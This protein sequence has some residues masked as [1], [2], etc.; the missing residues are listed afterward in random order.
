MLG[1]WGAIGEPPPASPPARRGH[2]A[3]QGVHGEGSCLHGDGWQCRIGTGRPGS[4]LHGNGSHLHQ[5][6]VWLRLCL[7]Q[8]RACTGMGHTCTEVVFAQGR[9]SFAPVSCLHRDGDIC[10]RVPFAPGTHLHVIVFAQGRV[11]FAPGLCLMGTVPF[12][13]GR[14]RLH[15][16]DHIATGRATFARGW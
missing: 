6:C 5:G 8:R 10:A 4:Y 7:H 14:W 13:W 3:A 12:A 16:N 2:A 15:E 1:V 9:G 11:A